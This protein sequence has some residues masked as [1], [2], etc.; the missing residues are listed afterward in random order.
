MSA[1]SSARRRRGASAPV[2]PWPLAL[3]LLALLCLSPPARAEAADPGPDEAP[4]LRVMVAEGPREVFDALLADLAAP[5]RLRLPVAVTRDG[6][7]AAFQAFCGHGGGEGPDVVLSQTRLPMALAAECGGG[8]MQGVVAVEL[9]REPLVLAVRG[10]GAGGLAR[11]TSEQV[12]LALARDVPYK[13]E[14]HRNV[15]IRW[16]DIDPALPPLDIRFQVP[17]RDDGLRAVFDTTVL[18]MGCR[19]EPLAM[20]LAGAAERQARC[21][22][23]RADR[24]REIP[25][26]QAVRALLDAPEGTVGVLALR[27]LEQANQERAGAL[28]G[29]E[30]DET[31]PRRADIEQAVF[32]HSGSLWLYARQ[33]P[34]GAAPRRAAAIAELTGRAQSDA[35]AGP[36]GLLAR[37][38]V[39]PLP[40]DERAAQRAAL[41]PRPPQYSLAWAAGWGASLLAGARDAVS[42]TFQ[43]GGERID[44]RAADLASLMD[45]AGYKLQEFES[46][47][48]IV[49]SATMTFGLARQMTEADRDALERALKLDARARAHATAA[50]QRW[51]VRTVLDVRET[52]GYVVSRVELTL[53]PL[54]EVRLIV[55]VGDAER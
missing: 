47:V 52:Q 44:P 9:G 11:L 19:A 6:A 32:D 30:L 13:E 21:A 36:G 4:T 1:S 17:P 16:S 49:P 27:E 25:R 55:A 46:S 45:L 14:F 5:A 39:T 2:A 7:A 24:V 43:R 20:R 3:P 18:A 38:G 8:G 23:L 22:T 41:A 15:A 33:G 40:E 50:V 31:P 26:A 10:G 54:P 48:G 51:V 28:A 12:R 42:A 53:F 37:L 35:V 29:L 34:A